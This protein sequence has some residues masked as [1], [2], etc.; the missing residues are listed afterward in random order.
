MRRTRAKL[1]TLDTAHELL[2]SLERANTLTYLT[3]LKWPNCS[4]NRV[5]SALTRWL[6]NPLMPLKDIIGFGENTPLTSSLIYNKCKLSLMILLR[7]WRLGWYVT[8]RRT[9]FPSFYLGLIFLEKLNLSFDISLS[10]ISPGHLFLTNHDLRF[11][12]WPSNFCSNEQSLLKRKGW[13]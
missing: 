4:P 6:F 13:L 11:L 2:Q 8:T 1:S 5:Y 3:C 7:Q 9:P 12:M 10:K